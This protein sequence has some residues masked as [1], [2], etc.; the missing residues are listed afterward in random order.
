MSALAIVIQ[1]EAWL[2]LAAVALIVL[3]RFVRAEINIG[4]AQLSRMQ[5][6]SA[7]IG[8]AAYYLSLVV[9]NTD[10]TTLPE[11]GMPAAAAFGSSSLVYL[12]NKLAQL[13][14]AITNAD[15]N[16]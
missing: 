4:H 15:R 7:S 16:T 11:P 2:F 5:F 3:F 1:I 8:F 14:P 13:W 12:F 10:A 9:S 6:L